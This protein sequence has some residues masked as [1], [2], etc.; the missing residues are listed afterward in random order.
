MYQ[1]KEGNRADAQIDF[2]IQETDVV[3]SEI[4][5]PQ[6]KKKSDTVL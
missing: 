2:D 6:Q 4:V 3:L 5:K 1:R